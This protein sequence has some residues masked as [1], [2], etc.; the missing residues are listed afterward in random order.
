[1][2]GPALILAGYGTGDSLQLTVES[3]R[4]MARASRVFAIGLPP[5]LERLLKGQRIRAVDLSSCFAAGRP[6]TEV[7][8]DIADTL[9]RQ[10]ADDPPV[11]LLSEGNPLLSNSLNRFILV[12][13]K[14]R[15]LVTQVLPGVSPIDAAICQ[16]GLD[17]GTFGLQVFDA[18]RVYTREMPIQSSVPLLLLQVAGVAL[19]EASPVFAPRPGAYRELS[20]YLGRFYPPTHPVVHLANSADPQAAAASAAPL[21]AFDSLVP[22]FGPA[23]T[24]FVDLLRLPR[25]AEG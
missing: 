3:Q 13:A 4:A 22:R 8:L 20:D 24:L 12:Q 9:L 25:A 18:R 15:K 19:S 1:M 23:S 5:N 14:E 2:A 16:V 21:S 11:L 17:V 7:Y 6:F 10:A